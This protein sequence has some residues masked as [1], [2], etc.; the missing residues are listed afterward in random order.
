MKKNPI[1][2]IVA[3]EL[4]PIGYS[5]HQPDTLIARIRYDVRKLRRLSDDE[6][7][8]LLFEKTLRLYPFAIVDPTTMR[9]YSK[10]TA[11]MQVG[12]PLS[13]E[14]KTST[15]QNSSEPTDHK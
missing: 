13:P 9:R 5:A 7:S 14:L 8:I 10:R 6:L 1:D 15:I 12:L 4:I 11:N 2:K 3:K